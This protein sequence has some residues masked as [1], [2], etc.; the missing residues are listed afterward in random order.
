MPRLRLKSGRKVVSTAKA[1]KTLVRKKHNMAK[2][3]FIES[4]DTDTDTNG[5][6]E[7]SSS[8][9]S[10]DSD[11]ELDD[12]F[13]MKA[14]RKRLNKGKLPLIF[15]WLIPLKVIW[16]F[17][18]SKCRKMDKRRRYKI[19]AT[20]RRVRREM[21]IDFSAFPRQIWLPVSTALD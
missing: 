5:P 16:K 17:L 14:A 6:L 1:R 2:V 20:G 13:Q 7:D 9:E 10:Y 15:F 19:K 4:S 8:Q 3:N 12:L 18:I 11:A 21:G